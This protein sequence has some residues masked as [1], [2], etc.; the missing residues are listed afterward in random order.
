MAEKTNTGLV[1]YAKVQ[2]DNNRP[3]W[4]GTYG[5][6]ADAK[7]LASKRAQYKDQYNKW[8][9]ESF[10]C[11]FGQKVHDCSGLIK[12]YMFS[13]NPDDPE[14]KYD[15]KYDKSANGMIQSCTETGDIKTIPE[16]PGLIVW[17]ENHVG[18]Y[19]GAGIVYEA[20]G[21]KQGCI[22]SR[23][24]DTAWKKWGRLS[25][26]RYE[27]T[28][29]PAPTPEKTCQATAPVLRRGDKNDSVGRY[30]V[31]ANTYGAGLEVD[32]KFGPDTEKKTK[33]LQAKF[34]L[35]NDGIVGSD[36]WSALLTGTGR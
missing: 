9:L 8:P 24:S 23:L 17:K 34:G 31:L 15:A 25:F 6:K 21:H 33:A 18:V 10:T 36:T 7:L 32:N 16:I 28:P 26:I 19:A 30:Q 11:Q 1:E 12:G 29:A 14:P 20:K 27:E 5:T 13:T 3:Y 4:Y 2:A 35:E 22:R